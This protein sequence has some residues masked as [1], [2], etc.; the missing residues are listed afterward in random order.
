MPPNWTDSKASATFYTDDLFWTP[1]ALGIAYDFTAVST[2]LFRSIVTLEP[3]LWGMQP[4]C[5]Q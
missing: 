1:L 2:G 4:L 5:L 3:A